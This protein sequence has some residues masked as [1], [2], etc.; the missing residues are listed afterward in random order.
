MLVL[1]CFPLLVPYSF[2]EKSLLAFSIK[3]F[4][5]RGDQGYELIDSCVPN[6]SVK[7]NCYI[8]PTEELELD[9]LRLLDSDSQS[10]LSSILNTKLFYTT[11]N[12]AEIYYFKI[13][14]GAGTRRRLSPYRPRFRVYF[15][16]GDPGDPKPYP[17]QRTQR[18]PSVMDRDAAKDTE[19]VLPIPRGGASLS[20]LE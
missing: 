4:N 11:L 19:V 3:E 1:I 10:F 15:I 16:T 12:W 8:I 7:F 17:K 13:D 6:L 14:R 5:Y 20:E 18:L 2:E 9:R